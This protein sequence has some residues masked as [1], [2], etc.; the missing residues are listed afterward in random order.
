MLK[1]I[2]FYLSLS[3]LLSPR[4]L[5]FK[6][7][8]PFTNR[9]LYNNSNAL[10]TFQYLKTPTFLVYGVGKFCWKLIE[11]VYWHTQRAKVSN[12]IIAGTHFSA[13]VCFAQSPIGSKFQSRLMTYRS[14]KHIPRFDVALTPRSPTTLECFTF[15]YLFIFHF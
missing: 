2:A 14:H 6:H 4:H 15:I 13:L 5:P 9:W 8:F 7:L 12:T 1:S 3:P 11:K 10:I